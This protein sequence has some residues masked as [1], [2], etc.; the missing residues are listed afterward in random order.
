MKG[1]SGLGGCQDEGVVRM[2]GV[3]KVREVV[4]EI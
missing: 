2:R 4:R 1:L 3:V